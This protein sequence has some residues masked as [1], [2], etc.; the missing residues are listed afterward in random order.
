MPSGRRF[1]VTIDSRPVTQPDMEFTA[2]FFQRRLRHIL[3]AEGDS[4]RG[5]AEVR[6]PAAFGFSRRRARPIAEHAPASFSTRV[7]G[8][9]RSIDELVLDYGRSQHGKPE[10]ATTPAAVAIAEID[11]RLVRAPATDWK[12]VCY[13]LMSGGLDPALA[14]FFRANLSSGSTFVDIGAS[15]GAYTLLAAGLN[16]TGVTHSFEADAEAYAWLLRNVE[17]AGF[18]GDRVQ[19]KRLSIA[20]PGNAAVDDLIPS[21]QKVDMVRIGGPSGILE[22]LLGMRRICPENAACRIVVDFCAAL[23]IGSLDLDSTVAEIE[24][25][26][27]TVQRIDSGTG[28]PTPLLRDDLRGAFSINL[29][30]QQGRNMQWSR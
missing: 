30:L 2:S 3:A 25:I 28:E 23:H 29:L 12:R 1:I 11:G 14:R 5:H 10:T 17:D 21:G 4:V 9:S 19:P 15:L 22:T 13:Y 24:R 20:G 6:R 18:G 7:A 16:S 27:F 26:G 8:L